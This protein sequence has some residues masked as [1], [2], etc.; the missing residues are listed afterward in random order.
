MKNLNLWITIE[1][2]VIL[3]LMKSICIKSFLYY[4]LFNYNEIY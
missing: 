4:L 2:Q 1:Y 3:S